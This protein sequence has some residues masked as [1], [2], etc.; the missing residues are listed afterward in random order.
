MKHYQWSHV[1]LTFYIPY[2]ATFIYLECSAHCT[3]CLDADLD[4]DPETCIACED[5]YYLNN[6]QCE[7]ELSCNMMR[8][9]EVKSSCH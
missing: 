9:D 5:Y 2:C 6:R 4:D 3:S 8:Y 1:I 7:G